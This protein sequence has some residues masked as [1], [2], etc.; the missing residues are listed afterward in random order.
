MAKK[1]LKNVFI[2]LTLTLI[3]SYY[4]LANYADT[5][6]RGLLPIAI[7]LKFMEYDTM[8]NRLKFREG[9]IT[10]VDPPGSFM[11]RL[12]PYNEALDDLRAQL[13]QQS[14]LPW[15]DLNDDITI[16]DGKKDELLY[17]TSN[18]KLYTLALKR[19]SMTRKV[20]SYSCLNDT[21]NYLVQN[22]YMWSS[23]S[24][25]CDYLKRRPDYSSSQSLLIY[26]CNE[27]LTKSQTPECLKPIDHYHYSAKTVDRK[28]EPNSS[29]PEYYL[30][31]YPEYIFYINALHDGVV[32]ADG[33]VFTQ[34]VKIVDVVCEQQYSVNPPKNYANSSLY[35]EVFVIS[36]HWGKAYFHKHGED[37]PR[38]APYL[39]FLT[40]NKAIK[41]HVTET[42]VNSVTAKTLMMLGIN[43]NRLVKG[44]IR[45]KIV[46]LPQVTSC[47]YSNQHS[48]QLV[49]RL[50]RQYVDRNIT[51]NRRNSMV[52]I[53]RTKKRLLVDYDKKER[54]MLEVAE[55][56]NLKFEV[57]SDNA[58][59]SFLDQVKLFRRAAVVIGSHGAGL[60]NM[61]FSEP[62]T[63]VIEGTCSPPG[64]MMAYVRLAHIL[65]HYYHA[66]PSLGKW[67]GSVNIKTDTFI[68]E[69]KKVIDA[70]FTKNK[71]N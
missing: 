33:Y 28:S 4:Y 46:Y 56:Y 5:V 67:T 50:Y 22:Y 12:L 19:H 21:S 23:T 26:Q 58:L 38:I 20:G 27:D 47:G 6:T 11:E 45:A 69:A 52:M 60:V 32:N 61:I 62:G 43:S 59:P 42:R 16:L 31:N 48:A 68:T 37:I 40:K 14:H 29:F 63:L 10:W 70:H 7:E 65:G 2:F 36:Q 55:D 66:I 9:Q 71:N 41:I 34:S 13:S 25:Y 1:K 51:D 24:P 30:N 15:R 3:F 17:V 54:A 39:A 57:L 8:K 44:D 49:S 53:H 35:P 18:T 64:L